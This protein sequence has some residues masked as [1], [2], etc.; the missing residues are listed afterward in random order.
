MARKL[1]RAGLVEGG[2]CFC[3][4]PDGRTTVIPFHSGELPK[5]IFRKIRKDAGISV[6]E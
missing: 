4:H 3:Q 2:R 6:E 5:G 1:K